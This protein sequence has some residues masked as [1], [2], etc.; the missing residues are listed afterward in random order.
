MIAERPCGS[1]D[2][3]LDLS[4]LREMH[5]PVRMLRQF[6][7]VRQNLAT[8]FRADGHLPFFLAGER[9]AIQD[10]L[11]LGLETR[12]LNNDASALREL[13]VADLE[14]SL[15]SAQ[16]NARVVRRELQDLPFLDD[17]LLVRQGGDAVANA[18]ATPQA[19][20]VPRIVGAWP[21]L[22]DV[23][24]LASRSARKTQR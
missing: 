2:L 22:H 15:G 17:E 16:N 20:P 7:E 9:Q 18:R 24:R 19:S 4:V 10:A 14:R 12:Q 21:R 8:G 3:R 6:C 1:A 23:A 5:L 13:E 11:D